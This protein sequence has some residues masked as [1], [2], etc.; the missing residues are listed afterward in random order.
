M[1]APERGTE[2]LDI[3]VEAQI[4][5]VREAC[6]AGTR[7][8]SRGFAIWDGRQTGWLLGKFAAVQS[9]KL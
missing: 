4:G 2:K 3:A 6:G 1:S 5:E 8:Q 9:K 7:P